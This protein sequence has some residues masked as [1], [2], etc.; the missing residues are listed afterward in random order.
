MGSLHKLI[1]IIWPL[2]HLFYLCCFNV[3]MLILFIFL[4]SLVFQIHFKLPA[5]TISLKLMFTNPI[6]SH[7]N[8]D[9]WFHPSPESLSCVFRH[10]ISQCTVF[11]AQSHFYLEPGHRKHR[12]SSPAD[13][14]ATTAATIKCLAQ[15]ELSGSC[16]SEASYG[17]LTSWTCISSLLGTTLIPKHLSTN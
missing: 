12:Q 3:I 4:S 16:L 17:E 5:Y 6:N 14:W 2:R 8:E 9:L 7:Y 11:G 10:N 15:T 13:Y 1:A